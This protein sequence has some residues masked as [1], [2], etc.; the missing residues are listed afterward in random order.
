NTRSR[1]FSAL[2]ATLRELID[3]DRKRPIIIFQT[4]GDEAP[5]WENQRPSDYDLSTVYSE[6]E[7]SRAKIYTVIPGLRLIDVPEEDVIDRVEVMT[8]RAELARSKYKDMWL[9][10]ER[11]P[12][13][14][15]PNSN[16]SIN[17]PPNL[18]EKLFANRTNVLASK[19]NTMRKGQTAAA[20]VAD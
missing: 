1:Q 14:P 8:Q 17:L 7:K 15:D 2:L 6:A 10:M 3:D 16:N 13:K 9:G 5:R 4:D 12:P 20:H 18:R 19:A 11:L